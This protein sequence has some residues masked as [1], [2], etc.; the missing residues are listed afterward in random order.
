MTYKDKKTK[1]DITDMRKGG[2]LLA[3]MLD[4][5]KVMA[6]VGL[7]VWELEK[8]FI[9]QCQDNDVIP[10][11]LNYSMAG[12]PPFPTGLCLSINEQ[13]VHCFP[14]KGRILQKDDVVTIDTVIKYNRVFLDCAITF[15]VGHLQEDKQRLI[16]TTQKALDESIKKIKAGVKTG[17][18]SNTIQKI[19]EK[20]GYSVLRDYAGHGIGLSMHEYPEIPC[21][22]N[23]TEGAILEPGMAVS[24]EPLVC[25]K[26]YVLQHNN[27]WETKTADGGYFAQ[28]EHTVLV[29]PQGYEV[30][31]K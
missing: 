13:A 30:L 23:K 5:L 22:G 3:A 29:T 26:N 11:C 2:H 8:T 27:F 12:F 15:G 14:V 7:D 17:V 16:D 4:E 21:Y 9:R 18:I 19:I 20:E 10:A 6:K 1:K 28:I 31:T 24:I 25:E